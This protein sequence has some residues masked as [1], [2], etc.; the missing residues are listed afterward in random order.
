MAFGQSSFTIEAS[1]ILNERSSF[2]LLTVKIK[3]KVRF[4]RIER[5]LS[6]QAPSTCKSQTLTKPKAN[7]AF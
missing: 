6:C 4:P 7:F 2:L 3:K 5:S 1:K